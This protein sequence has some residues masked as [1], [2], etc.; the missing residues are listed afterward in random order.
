LPCGSTRTYQWLN[1]TGIFGMGRD[2]YDY[3]D[4]ISHDQ[5]VAET[6]K[7]ISQEGVRTYL[8]VHG[9]A[10]DF[11]VKDC[12]EQARNL[13]AYGFHRQAI[14]S[15]AI[16]IEL[17]V[18]FLLVRPLIQAAFLD[19]DWAYL[20]TKKIT[21][22][23]SIHDRNLLPEILRYHDIKISDVKLSAG[24]ELWQTVI[25]TVYPKRDRIVH[26]G[27]SATLEEAKIA[28]EC[29]SLLREKVVLPLAKKVGFTLETT[30]CWHKTK[31]DK[32]SSQYAER[33]PFDPRK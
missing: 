14:L 13:N 10:V 23:P 29:A 19:E 21:S 31:T 6:L 27:E 1:Q 12:I 5:F 28:V 11:R 30:G 15:A 26:E 20:L 32:S 17:I 22:G 33:N 4:E 7:N 2:Y 3:E 24:P 16:A 18:R 25:K 9:D 8:G